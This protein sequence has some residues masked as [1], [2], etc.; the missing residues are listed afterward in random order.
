VL[1][2]NRLVWH[3]FQASLYTI[4]GSVYTT[5]TPSTGQ[6]VVQKAIIADWT[7]PNLLLPSILTAKTTWFPIMTPIGLRLSVGVTAANGA[8]LMT[9]IMA[10][11]TTTG[12]ATWLIRNA[13]AYPNVIVSGGGGNKVNRI[14]RRSKTLNSST[15]SAPA[16]EETV[17]MEQS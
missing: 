5:S 6:V 15:D 7:V 16:S 3:T 9:Q 17:I 1:F 12:V 2:N 14:A 4:N 11:K 10:R 8:A 13:V